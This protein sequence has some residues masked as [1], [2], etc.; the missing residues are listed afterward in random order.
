MGVGAGVVPFQRI[1]EAHIVPM[2][3]GF[4]AQES[5][6]ARLPR[7]GDQGSGKTLHGTVQG[8][9]KQAMDVHLTILRSEFSIVKLDPPNPLRIHGSLARLS[10]IGV[11]IARGF[12][13][14]SD[15]LKGKRLVPPLVKGG[16]GGFS[17]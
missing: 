3:C 16:I 5:S 15:F 8:V 17:S 11:M 10:P 14:T 4:A 6:L 9:L 2:G 13:V 7:A 1:V 12:G